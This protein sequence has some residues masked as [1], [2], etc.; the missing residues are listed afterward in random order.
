MDRVSDVAAFPT[1]AE[2]YSTTGVSSILGGP[3]W[4]PCNSFPAVVASM[5]LLDSLLLLVYLPAFTGEPAVADDP[6]VVVALL[7]L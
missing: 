3:Y 2:V 1:A 5:L 6:V 7:L 4:P